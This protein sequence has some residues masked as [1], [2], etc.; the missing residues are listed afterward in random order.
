MNIKK[1]IIPGLLLCG[2][3]IGSAFIM[4]A[5]TEPTTGPTST[6]SYPPVNVGNLKQVRTG[7]LGIG[8]GTTA[9]D[10]SLTA[11]NTLYFSTVVG[12]D[13]LNV[14][15]N[16]T[17]V[18]NTAVGGRMI[19]AGALRAPEL[20]IPRSGLISSTS[21]EDYADKMKNVSY[22]GYNPTYEYYAALNFPK[23][24]TSNLGK[25]K[26][27]TTDANKAC[28]IG[29]AVSK[30]N[31]STGVT[32]CRSINPST[33]TASSAC[34]TPFNLTLN[35][36]TLVSTATNN[37]T[38][39]KAKLKYSATWNSSTVGT[40]ERL[41]REQDVSNW[42]HMQYWE[43]KDVGSNE[44]T[45]VGE[46]DSNTLYHNPPY[47]DSYGSGSDQY[48]IVPMSGT[49]TKLYDL[50]SKMIPIGTGLVRISDPIAV[51]SVVG[52]GC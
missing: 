3:L 23:D 1:S 17:L 34:P 22:G 41:M 37:P 26:V 47:A 50:R 2:I 32:T 13:S 30:Y 46:G 14:N 24:T 43:K 19:V 39:C 27:C 21:V 10:S 49:S 42:W 29:W 38:N 18:G 8:N 33:S 31:S 40:D 11:A 51:Y 15:Q 48:V 7:G 44:W 25:G 4:S 52:G 20:L 28:P 6:T 35:N 45:F 36:P 12:L 16:A 9:A 5:F